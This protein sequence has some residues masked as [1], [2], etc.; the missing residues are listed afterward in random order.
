MSSI[1]GSRGRHY[2]QMYRKAGG[3][4]TRGRVHRLAT[5]AATR[6]AS[7]REVVDRID[8]TLRIPL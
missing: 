5:L 7:T 2:E 8:E 1:R 3:V 6:S 4:G